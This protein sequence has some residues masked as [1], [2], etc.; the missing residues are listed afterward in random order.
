MSW[1][2][3]HNKNKLPIHANNGVL[4]HVTIRDYGGPFG[5]GTWHIPFKG[6]TTLPMFGIGG[7]GESIEHV[8]EHKLGSLD[9]TSATYKPWFNDK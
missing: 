2:F 1:E 5:G 8:A 6:Q 7:K 9:F 3:A 4:P